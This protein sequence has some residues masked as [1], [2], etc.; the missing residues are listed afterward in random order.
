VWRG[1]HPE[2]LRAHAH[3]RRAITL[4]LS[5]WL[6]EADWQQILADHD[7]ACAYCGRTDLPLTRDHCI[8]LSQGGTDTIRNVVPACLSHNCAKHT[9][10]AYFPPD[11]LDEMTFIGRA[12]ANA[13]AHRN[14]KAQP[15][16]FLYPASVP[17][18]AAGTS[19]ALTP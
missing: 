14:D 12:L 17:K 1:A 8:P 4:G 3:K 2:A 7:Y 9:R 11:V 16:E 19:A 6:T 18:L 10:T 13:I 15:T 5:E